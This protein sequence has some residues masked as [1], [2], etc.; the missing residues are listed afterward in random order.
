MALFL[1]V[2]I[3]T[4]TAKATVL[5]ENCR[6]VYNT[7]EKVRVMSPKPGFY[8]VDAD[9]TWW[10]TFVKILKKMSLVLDLYQ[11]EAV[12]IS[13]VCGSFVP[14]DENLR[15]LRRAIMYGIDRRAINEVEYLNRAFDEKYLI[16]RL[17]SK[18]TTHSLIPKFLW[19]RN[20][21]PDIYTKTRYFVESSNYITSKLTGETAWD[22]PTVSGCQL[23]DLPT[24]AYPSEMLDQIGID[25]S[26]LPKLL[27]PS[28]VLS[29]VSRKAS[30]ITGL[31]RGTKVFVGA[32]DINMESMSC[33]ATK[34]GDLL[35]TLGSTTS[36]L[37]NTGNL[38]FR[39]GFVSGV[40]LEVGVYRLGGATSSGAR[41]I[42]A[43]KKLFRPSRKKA[44]GMETVPKLPTGII[45]LP[46]LD[47]ARCPYHDPHAVGVLYGLRSDT[48][49]EDLENAFLEA[50][51][52]EVAVIIGRI[53]D[54]VPHNRPIHVTGGLSKIPSL[55]KLLA[56]VTGKAL[57]VHSNVD[58]SLGAAL[59]TIDNTLLTD[60]KCYKDDGHLVYPDLELSNKY[61]YYIK[62]YDLLYRTL[63]MKDR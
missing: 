41:F 30:E 13:S 29:T 17:G 61:S 38:V 39:E 5:D 54:L 14:V 15:P 16:H 3:G 45:I 27:W 20:N 56:S 7:A 32:C 2:D 42:Q 40:S 12:C 23:L 25:P 59:M 35:I 26:K 57:Q 1:G 18:F 10:Q 36:I 44:R 21:E 33:G 63:F 34:P 52:V 46:Y 6:I 60:L 48:T 51:A 4:S 55:V 31:K 24:M 47:G 43:M 53:S 58:A 62:E 22:F 8:E 19:L 11:I 9:K 50:L 37:L 49:L 28:Q